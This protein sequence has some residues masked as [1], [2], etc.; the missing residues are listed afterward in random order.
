M[1]RTRREYSH[2]ANI[3]PGFV[4][5]LATLLLSIIFLLVIFVVAQVMLSQAITGKDKALDKLNKQVAELAQLLDLERLA[6]AD[7]RLNI[8][9]LSQ[10]LQQAM[11]DRDKL[12]IKIEKLGERVQIDR[13]ALID[14]ED[15]LQGRQ[16]KI[17]RH[18]LEIASLKEDIDALKDLRQ[19]LEAKIAKLAAKLRAATAVADASRKKSRQLTVDLTA[20]RDRTK[21]LEARLASEK[22]RT[23]LAQTDLEE[24]G[25]YLS[26]LSR[27]YDN[28]TKAHDKSVTLSEKQAAQIAMLN[29]QLRE[30]QDT[31][32]TLNNALEAY[33]EKDRKQRAVI[34]QLGKRLNKALASKVAELAKYRSEFFGRLRRILGD[35]KDVRVSGDRF[36]F[37]SEVLFASGSANLGEAGKGQLRRLAGALRTISRNIPADINWILRVDGHTDNIPISTRAFPS[38][39]ELSTAR[40]IS[41]VRYLIAAGIPAKRLA[42]T[43]F[44][45]FQPLDHRKDDI[46]RRRN[47]RIEM[48][49]T[50]R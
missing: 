30:L 29:Q 27:R 41:V 39:W 38:N 43:G 36:I 23:R 26:E 8:T 48:K 6:N 28:L 31:L 22:E 35:R 12:N 7:L 45:Q 5:A 17:R 9:Q 13:R 21:R 4:D 46:A 32:K 33:D 42:A 34:K 44:G 40:A 1:P 3:W 20:L 19:E 18:L 47:R 14:T 15:R 11:T 37:Q 2:T 16:K 10:S 50:Q 25:V 49:F 24:R